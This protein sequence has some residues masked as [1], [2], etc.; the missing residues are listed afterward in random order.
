MGHRAVSLRGAGAYS[1]APHL[2]VMCI[3]YNDEIK[4]MTR[5]LNQRNS[6]TTEMIKVSTPSSI[7]VAES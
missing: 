4:Y 7:Y 1:G 5:V 2:H 3:K 6:Y